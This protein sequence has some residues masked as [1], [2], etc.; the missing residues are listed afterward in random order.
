MRTSVYKFEKYNY[1]RD[2]Y[3][4][5][6][7]QKYY[8]KCNV[9]KA[10]VYPRNFEFHSLEYH[11]IHERICC[12]W[13][14]GNVYWIHGNKY[15]YSSHLKKCSRKYIARFKDIQEMTKR[16]ELCNALNQDNDSH[17]PKSYISNKCFEPT[18]II[19]SNVCI[20]NKLNVP[21]D[22]NQTLSE[23]LEFIVNLL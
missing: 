3:A 15:R 1:L 6:R 21:N 11:K 18:D 20:S 19:Y 22:P 17:D 8:I 13:C 4:Y 12:V 2:Y 9:C 16:T 23:K 5:L 7:D 14:S 10:F